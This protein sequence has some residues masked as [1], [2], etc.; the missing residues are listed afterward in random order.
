MTTDLQLTGSDCGQEFTFSSEDQA[1]F[2]GTRLFGSETVQDLS[3]GKEERA[4]RRG[5]KLPE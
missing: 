4:G 5:R 3:P 1:F 2:S